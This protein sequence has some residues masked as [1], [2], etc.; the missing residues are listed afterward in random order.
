MVPSTSIG[1]HSAS[2]WH[3]FPST[4]C[5]L[6]SKVIT[7]P[8]GNINAIG[9]SP[10]T[11]DVLVW[12]DKGGGFSLVDF[13]CVCIHACVCMCMCMCVYKCMCMCMPT[14]ACICMYRSVWMHVCACV[15]MSVCMH[16]C[17]CMCIC[18]CVSSCVRVYNPGS[19]PTWVVPVLLEWRVRNWSLH[20]KSPH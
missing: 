20:D 14:S 3:K 15:C 12:V 9:L 4:V 1:K 16:T 5:L 18:V 6:P 10:C 8:C 17:S 13:V 19:W 7:E 2:G 11:V